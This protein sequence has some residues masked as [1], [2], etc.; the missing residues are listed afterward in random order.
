MPL[1]EGYIGLTIDNFLKQLDRVGRATNVGIGFL[2]FGFAM[3]L[4]CG[5]PYTSEIIY[6]HDI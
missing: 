6:Y 4:V 3:N 5:G 2:F 1:N